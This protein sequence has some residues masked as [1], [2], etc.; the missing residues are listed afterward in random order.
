MQALQLPLLDIRTDRIESNSD[1]IFYA[2]STSFA[3][4][5]LPFRLLKQVYL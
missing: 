3:F 5:L 2:A 4:K 1:E